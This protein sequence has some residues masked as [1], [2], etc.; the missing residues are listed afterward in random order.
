MIATSK[1]LYRSNKDYILL[2][3]CA[4]VADYFGVDPIIVRLIFVALSLGGGSGV[5]VYIVLAL[6]IPKEP[7]L[8]KIVDRKEKVEEFATEVGEK[9]KKLGKEIKFDEM[10]KDKKNGFLALAVIMLG[11]FLLLNQMTPGWFRWDLFWPVMVILAGVYLMV[12]K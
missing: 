1:K 10:K 4:G 9:V 3:V 12:K 2:G 8:E 11:L 7:G 5:L 6:V